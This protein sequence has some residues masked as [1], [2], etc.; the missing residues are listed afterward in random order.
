MKKENMIQSCRSKNS[1]SFGKKD[2][3]QK[4]NQAPD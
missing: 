4:S 3:S 2:I 1:I